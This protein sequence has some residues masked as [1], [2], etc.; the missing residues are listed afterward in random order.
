MK[1]CKVVQERTL[2]VKDS[3]SL[4]FVY[5]RDYKFRPCFRNHTDI[6]RVFGDVVDEERLLLVTAVPTS[7]FPKGFLISPPNPDCTLWKVGLA[8]SVLPHPPA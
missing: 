7:P 3:D 1:G 8:V 5:E 4:V 2:Q 6:S